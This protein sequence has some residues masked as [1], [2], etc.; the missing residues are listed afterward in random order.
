MQ[1]KNLHQYANF[2]KNYDLT[3]NDYI[4]AR[5]VKQYDDEGNALPST[6]DVERYNL[7]KELNSKNHKEMTARYNM[8]KRI[9]AR[10]SDYELP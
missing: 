2:L 9:V 3:L 10:V 1:I 5:S 8:R 7:I 4:F 6:F